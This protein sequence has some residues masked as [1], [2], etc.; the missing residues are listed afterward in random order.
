MMRS[1]TT[2]RTASASRAEA[3]THLDRLRACVLIERSRLLLAGSSSPPPAVAPTRI[4]TDTPHFD[5]PALRELARRARAFAETLS[6]IYQRVM[7]EKA[8]RLEREAA[9]QEA[10]AR[11]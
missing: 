1:E 11:P 6:P 5:A 4:G 7:I 2:E 8:Q 10:D 3:G 9:Q